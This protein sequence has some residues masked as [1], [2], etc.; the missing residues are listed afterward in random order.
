MILDV[1]FLGKCLR[2]Y[3]KTEA[4]TC[5]LFHVSGAR[6]RKELSVQKGHFGNVEHDNFGAR[7]EGQIRSSQT[8]NT[9]FD[10]PSL[11]RP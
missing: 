8:L 3:L 4:A 1:C 10:S 7:E 11:P 6:V 5:N 2:A 9:A